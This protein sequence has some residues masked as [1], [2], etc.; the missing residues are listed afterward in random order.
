MLVALMLCPAGAGAQSFFNLTADEVRIDTVLP[1]FSYS[2][3]L[4]YNYADSVYDVTIEYPEF[5]EMTEADIRRYK[6]ITSDTLPAMPAVTHR[7]GVSRKRGSLDVYIVPLAFRDGKYCK[8][9]SFKLAFSARPAARRAVS[10]ADGMRAS[11][12]SGRYASASVLRSGSWAKIRVPRSGVY[13]ITDALARQAGFSS[14]ESVR[15][16]GYGGA[17]QPEKLTDGYLR[18]TD[19]LQQVAVCNAGGKKL[20]Y[21]QGPVSWTSSDVRVRNPYSDYGYY[22]LTESDEPQLTADSTEFVSGFYPSGDDYNTL[23][24]VDD[25]SWFHGGRN[26]YDSKVLTVGTP[27]D[28]TL[29]APG[30]TTAGTVTVVLTANGVAAASVS[31]N[32]SV[33]GTFSFG[34]LGDYEAAKEMKQIY[35]VA[36][37]AASNKVSVTQTSGGTM[38]LDYISLHSNEPKAA[39]ALSAT[40]FPVPEYVYRIT[41]QNHHAD[42][43]ADMIIIVPTTQKLRAQAERLKALRERVDTMRVRIVPADELYNE[44]SSG[45]PDATAYR[46]YMKMLY[47]RAESDADMPRYLVMFGDGAW[48]NRMLTSDWRGYSPDDFLLCF[49]SDDSFSDTKCFVSDDFSCMLDDGETI[50]DNGSYY[51]CYGKPDVAVGRFPVRTEEEA[52]TM[53]DKIVAYEGNGNAGAW[54]N[55]IVIMGD[56]GNYNIHMKTAD[57]VA[58]MVNKE[59]PKYNVKKIMWDAYNRVSSSTGNSYPDVTTLIKQYMSNGALI[60][61]YNGHGVNYCISHEQVVKLADFKNAVSKKLPLWLTASCDIMP[62]DGQE[63]NIGEAAMF[64]KNGGAVAFYGT[65]RTVYSNYNEL[66]NMAFTREVLRTDGGRVGIGEAARR[67]KCQLVTNSGGDNTAN[68]LQYTLLGDPA[69]KLACPTL[70]VVIDSINDVAVD[71]GGTLTLKAG[72]AVTVKGRV[73]D[74]GV[75]AAGF[76]GLLTATVSD[77]L[78]K[79]VCKLNNT[80]PKD[81][82]D[83]AFVFEDRSNVVFNGSD[84]VRDGAFSFSFAVP[85]DISYSDGTGLISVYAV[86]ADKAKTATGINGSFVL[87][88]SSDLSRDSIGP[89]IYCYINSTSFS[90]GDCVNPTPY[91]VAEISDDNGINATGSGVG[92][93]LRLIIDGDMSKTYVLNDYFTFDFGSYKSGTLGYSIPRLEAGEHKLQFRAWDVLNNSSTAELTFR[94]ENGVEPNII[95]VDCTR[96][97]ASTTTSFRIIHDRIGTQMDVVLDVFD[98]SGRHLWTHSESGVSTDNVLTVDW[99]LT[100]DGGRRLGTGVYLYRVRASCDGSSYASKAK[101]LIV[102]SNK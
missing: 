63:E 58:G 73:T 8:L 66:M 86:S 21:A 98:M 59:Y 26:L 54:Q 12:A 55:T 13:Q 68:K 42:E 51:Q 50:Q 47:D 62:F 69:L 100:I 49:E 74:N 57:K 99:D 60:M 46:R 53:V 94:V 43:A 14:A 101:K 29:S 82:A 70:D 79:V 24:E 27:S 95:D 11:S 19:D 4:G 33:V 84:N 87:N 78:Q 44:F 96:N 97:P 83:E 61:N 52:V 1:R 88:G 15:V 89:S 40:A 67:A 77:A 76:D 17:L 45:T 36:N 56:D 72:T 71:G 32:D 35:R 85:K 38:R 31:V 91:F 10:V 81:G 7:V 18:S 25:Y 65:T 90:N 34:K 6:A 3:D 2:H 23:Y 48:D 75:K 20:F 9:V 30:T 41:N 92:H 5:I 28:Y 39:P 102:I 22:F 64:N 80:D 93:D 37:L 16:Y